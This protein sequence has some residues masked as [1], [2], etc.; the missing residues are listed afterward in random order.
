MPRQPSGSF[1]VVLLADGSRAFRL[2][3][4]AHGRRQRDV[5]HERPGCACGCGGGW[6]E[7]AA[8]SELGN[9]IA[10]VRAGVWE[11]RVPAALSV[12][13]AT[14]PTFHEYASAWLTAK[15]QGILGDKPIDENTRSDYRW[16]LTRHLLPFFASYRLRRDRPR[17][18]PRVQGTQAAGGRTSFAKRSPPAP[19]SG[20][21]GPASTTGVGGLDPQADRHA[22]SDPRRRDRGRAD[23]PQPGSRKADARSR[24]EAGPHVPRD[25]R[26]GRAH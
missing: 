25:G 12:E 9:V 17:P 8:R 3:F 18:L 10:R 14:I 21:A 26:A 7:R 5:L 22:C 16:R 13:P 15:V 11:P 24:A 2:R 6:D 23:R 20:P 19:T 1:D 4:R